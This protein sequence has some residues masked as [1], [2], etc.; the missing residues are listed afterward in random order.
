MESRIRNSN[1]ALGHAFVDVARI[2]AMFCL[3]LH[4]RCFVG[5]ADLNLLLAG[6][7]S[8]RYEELQVCAALLFVFRCLWALRDVGCIDQLG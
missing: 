1:G 4:L 8:I 2:Y 5:V 6:W 7:D 3:G